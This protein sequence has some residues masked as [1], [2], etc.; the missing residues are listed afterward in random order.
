MIKANE[1][2]MQINDVFSCH[3]SCAGCILSSNER[4]SSIPTMSRETLLT[5]IDRM[6]DH[7]VRISPID[8]VNVIFGIG[9]HILYGSDYIAELHRLGSGVIKAA[10]PRIPERSVV[11]FSTSLVGKKDH[12]ISL[13]REVK[14]KISDD[15]PLVPQVVLD[16]RLLNAEKFGP[17]WKAMVAEAKKLFGKVDLATNLSVEAVAC[18]TPEQMILFAEENGFDE[19]VV[20]W[21]PTTLNAVSTLK[22]TTPILEWLIRFDAL[23]DQ[24]PWMNTTYR[25]VIAKM[26]RMKNSGSEPR[27]V[28][29]T[30]QEII[31]ESILKAFEIEPDGTIIPKFEAIGD[32]T[33]SQ[34][35]GFKDIGHINDGPIH[36][37]IQKAIGRVA[38]KVISIH[39][40]G[41][42][43]N[44][45]FSTACAGTGF[46]VATELRRKHF[47]R[48]GEGECP[49][50]ARALMERIESR[51]Q[52][53]LPC[54]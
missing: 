22:D 40:K 54:Q 16:G 8:K 15:V 21:A 44:C 27:S 18:M 50:V 19:V 1:L 31:P 7:A 39:A 52:Q 6:K 2:Q 17:R 38:A 48:E 28:L 29:E 36:E 43:A 10:N 42:C 26:L 20:N 24:K 14:S 37:V 12:V 53:G 9:D 5:A 23:A 4:G 30:A 49:H 34:R 35:H 13:L 45:R 51:V 46:H 25:P 11:F 32:V 3:G 33:H 41:S 47:G